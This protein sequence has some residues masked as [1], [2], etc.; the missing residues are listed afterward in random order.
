MATT[1]AHERAGRNRRKVEVLKRKAE[2]ANPSEKI[3]IAQKLDPDKIAT[4]VVDRNGRLLT[5]KVDPR[6]PHTK[7]RLRYFDNLR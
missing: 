1:D 2:S 7:R 3:N 5:Y 6:D 4:V